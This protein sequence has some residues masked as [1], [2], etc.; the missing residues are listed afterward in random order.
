MSRLGCE[1]HE[2]DERDLY[3]LMLFVYI[4]DGWHTSFGRLLTNNEAKF[5]Y[6]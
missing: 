5:K 4:A 2:H 1:G 6:L 3:L